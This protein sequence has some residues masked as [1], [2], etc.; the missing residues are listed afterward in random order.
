MTTQT[1]EEPQ[2]EQASTE[3]TVQSRAA[4][5]LGS[6]QTRLD[7]TELAL[8]SVNITEIKNSA[9]RAECHG[10]AMTL[11]NARIAIQKTGKTARDDA[12]KF[13][14]AVIDEEKSLIAITAAEETRLITLRDAWDQKIEA[15]KQAKAAAERARITAIHER[16]ASIKEYGVLALECR[17]AARVQTLI[18]KITLLIPAADA[19][20]EFQ[21]EAQRAYDQTLDRINAIHAQ[22]FADEAERAKVKAEQEAAAATLKAE[23]AELD[24]QRAAHEQR[25]RE[26]AAAHEQ[27][28][29]DAAAARAADEAAAQARLEA[30]AKEMERQRTELQIAAA[31]KAAEAEAEH[32]KRKAEMEE[33]TRA[34]R[35]IQLAETLR[36]EAALAALEEQRQAAEIAEQQVQAEQEKAKAEQQ[37]PAEPDAPQAP[38]P[39]DATAFITMVEIPPPTDPSEA[40]VIWCA[41]SAVSDA[42]GMTTTEAAARLAAVVWNPLSI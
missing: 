10:A 29:R 3:L 25:E 41:I 32:A 15:E 40:D 27:R 23:R 16:I 38:E 21:D 42:F 39:D 1:L 36:L 26:A 30:Q 11:A 22:K 14:K 18:D 28:E 31:A 20:E 17:T 34:A 7:L 6:S 13:S 9:G 12:T 37:T 2:V 35:A 19:F 8:K 33:E 24:A 4:L 5:A